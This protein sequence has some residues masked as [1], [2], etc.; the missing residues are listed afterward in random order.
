MVS[1]N[2]V[3]QEILSR[4]NHPSALAVTCLSKII[5]TSAMLL[6]IKPL[7]N[8]QRALVIKARMKIC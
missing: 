6:V 8:S 4:L 3:T 7:K 1:G 2:L 5:I